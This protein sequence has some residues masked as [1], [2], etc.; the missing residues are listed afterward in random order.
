[1]DALGFVEGPV[2]ILDEVQGIV[3]VQEHDAGA[4]RHPQVPLKEHNLVIVVG[5]HAV[6]PDSQREPCLFISTLVRG[7]CL[8]ARLLHARDLPPDPLLVP[9]FVKMHPVLVQLLAHG[10]GGDVHCEP[11]RRVVGGVAFALAP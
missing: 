4:S 9:R 1:M 10:L 7:K 5:D 2:E 3:L 8:L 11:S 6:P